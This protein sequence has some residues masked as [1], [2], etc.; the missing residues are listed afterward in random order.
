[1]ALNLRLNNHMKDTKKPDSDENTFINLN[2]DN[3]D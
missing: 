1:M 2:R 3:G